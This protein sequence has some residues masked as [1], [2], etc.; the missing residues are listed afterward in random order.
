MRLP[1]QPT[2]Q[3]P[4]DLVFTDISMPEMDGTTAAAEIR[5]FETEN[6]L[7]AVP[8]VAMTA[9]A[10]AEDKDRILASGIDDYLTKP[11]KKDDLFDRIRRHAP[12]GV[13]PFPN[14]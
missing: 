12:D 8:I 14:G 4:P 11:L 13:D 5:S 10:M 2:R 9:H 1:W 7:A 6:G 3:S